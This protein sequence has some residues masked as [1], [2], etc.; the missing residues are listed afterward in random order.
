[1][2][3]SLMRV[4]R[5]HG[6]RNLQVEQI[7]IPEP[8][9]GQLLVKLE[10]CGVCATDSRKYEIGVNDGEYPFNPGHEW[11]GRVSE[12]GA[13]VEGWNVGDR[14]YGDVYGGYA[15]YATIPV[16]P[17]PW[18][19]GPLRVPDD[20]PLERAILV[21]PFADCLHA[22]HD[23]AR[24]GSGN[25]LVVIAAGAMGLKI[26]VEAAR[27]GAKVLV[28]EPLAARRQLALDFGAEIAIDPENWRQQV[29]DWSGGQGVEAVILC[30]GNPD[31]VNDCMAACRPGGRVV[32]FAGFGNRP[33]A[34]INLNDIHYREIELVGSEWIGTPPNQRRHCYD[35]ALALLSDPQYPFQ[36]LVTGTCGFDDVE[37]ALVR[38]QNFEGLKIMFVP[39]PHS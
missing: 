2:S 16:Q 14:L 32:L 22:V 1:M 17:I 31:L 35:Q 21:E 15:E 30:I 28:V 23:Q 13:G 7:P 19:R 39:R 4:A 10:A 38:R 26:I 8:A 11:V 37:S 3:K 6:I 29:K 5:L 20:L 36:K 33:Q 9:P 34:M 27:I 24:I 18:S 12:V 25:R